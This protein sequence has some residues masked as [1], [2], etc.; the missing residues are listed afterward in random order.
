MLAVSIFS[1]MAFCWYMHQFIGH[2]LLVENAVLSTI[3]FMMFV[4]IFAD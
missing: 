3:R 1:D 2:N 4:F